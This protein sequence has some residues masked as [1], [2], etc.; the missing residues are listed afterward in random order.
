MMNT[1]TKTFEDFPVTFLEYEKTPYISHQSLA[2]YFKWT[3]D[4]RKRRFNSVAKPHPEMVA[5]FQCGPSREVQK[6]HHPFTSTKEFMNMTKAGLITRCLTKQG[7]I[8]TMMKENKHP[9]AT[10]FQKFGCAV[11][12]SYMTHGEVGRHE[13]NSL[14]ELTAKINAENE[15]KRLENERF[16]LELEKQ[17]MNFE[18]KKIENAELINVTEKQAEEIDQ[19]NNLRAHRLIN[20]RKGIQKPSQA[21]FDRV[22]KFIATLS[23][24]KIIWKNRIPCFRSLEAYQ[25]TI[26]AI[27][28]LRIYVPRSQRTVQWKLDNGKCAL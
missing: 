11:L 5:H 8:L 3:R 13:A 18:Q 20:E 10:E 15:T 1:L 23:R 2:D 24:R 7:L 9:R 4:T 22:C 27:D 12:D 6:L 14:V 17:R 21:E 16:R 26:P 28:R 25:A 19:L